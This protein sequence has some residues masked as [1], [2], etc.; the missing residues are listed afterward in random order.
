[1][2][3]KRFERQ[4]MLPEFGAE[5]QAALAGASVLIVGAGGL[6]APAAL[7][8]TAAGIGRIGIAD[9]DCVALSNLQRQVLYTENDI[10]KNKARC[11]AERLKLLSSE[12]VI[13]PFDFMLDADN[14]T[15]LAS[16]YD[17]IVDGCDNSDT[18]YLI[19]DV[20]KRLGI[21]YVYG[22]IAGFEGQVSLFNFRGGKG[23]DDLFPR[24][25]R[26]CGQTDSPTGVMGALPGIIGSIEAMEAVKV[27][28]GTGVT[29]RNR[30]LTVNALTMEFVTFSLD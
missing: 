28:T 2:N 26:V 5:G 15:A 14:M 3:V 4:I 13:T 10:G 23:Y 17:V 25:E 6:G 20:S 16:G 8:L 12:S 21:P 30:L 24:H 29:L 11:A 9:G 1:M 22:A 18:R 7:Y 19:N 27:I